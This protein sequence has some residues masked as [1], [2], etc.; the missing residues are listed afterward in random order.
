MKGSTVFFADIRAKCREDNRRSKVRRLLS[1]LD[2][3]SIVKEGDLTAVKVH[4]GEMGND[5]F[6]N[7]IYVGEVSD[8]V[9]E[10]GGRPFIT[11]S[12]TLY[13]GSRHVAVDHLETAVRNGFAYP[14]VRA[15]LLIA[16]GL[17]GRDHRD[18]RI[19][20]KH[21][22][23]VR[24]SSAIVDA[25]SLVVVS[26]FK[27]HETAGFGGAIKNLAMGCAPPLGKMDQHST[28]PKVNKVRCVGCGECASVCPVGAISIVEG[29]S[30]IDK[31]CVG[32]NECMTVCPEDA[33]GVNWDVEIPIFTERMVE[34]ASGAVQGKEK[35]TAYI[36]FL[37]DISPH[38]DCFPW[39]DSP[40][41]NDIGI[42]ASR[43][44]VA[45]DK[46]CWDLINE[47]AGLE[48]SLLKSGM[49]KG[50]DKIRGLWVGTRPDLQISHAE[51]LSLGSSSYE[52]KRI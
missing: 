25:D 11:D 6:V 45:I 7:P 23:R 29:I 36:N 15:P 50:Q 2:L 21:F 9:R 35:R 51:K 8:M 52:L 43:D 19:D 14:V 24:I 22:S 16:D 27:G 38:C 48:N 32:C 31:S 1:A 33:I 13:S 26:H 46:A 30:T 4:F 49:K 5:A 39:S 34:Y 42:L 3:G 10:A 44:P 40:I 17:K 47:Q 28:R 41:V 18:V 37:T 20:G 12:N